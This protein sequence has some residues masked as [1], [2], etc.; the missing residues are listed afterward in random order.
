MSRFRLVE[1]TDTLLQVAEEHWREVAP[2][3]LAE[4]GGLERWCATG[5]PVPGGRARGWRIPLGA[6]I[7]VHLREMAHGGVLRRLTGRRFLR[8]DRAI[9]GLEGA[10]ELR[11]RGVAVPAPVLLHARRRGP[12]WRLALAHEFVAGAESGDRLL[13]GDREPRGLVRAARAAGACVRRFHDA[14]GSHPDL[15]LGNLLVGDGDRVTVV[16]LEGV[17]VG[18]PPAIAQRRRELAR[19]LRSLSKQAV[20]PALRRRLVAAFLAG[21]LGRD[22]AFRAAWWGREAQPTG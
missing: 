14:G 4:P 13:S 22:E 2:L 17:R 10:A 1:T 7:D 6:G 19:L 16:D 21:Y 18:A 11:A 15:H 8:P 5:T 3:A 20:A 9:A 12:F